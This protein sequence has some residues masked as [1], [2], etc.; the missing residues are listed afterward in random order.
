MSDDWRYFMC[1]MGENLAS[2]MV[3]VGIAEKIQAAPKDLAVLTLT[4]HRPDERGLPT[5]E[6]F[7][8]VVAVEKQL[9]NFV[10]FG[11]DAYVGRITKEGVRNFFVYTARAESRW[12][13]LVDQLIA[14]SGYRIELSIDSDPAHQTYWKYLYPTPD[15]WRVIH[16][17]SVI[18]ALEKSGDD[19]A[20]QR[21]IE[22]WSYFPDE[23]MARRFA[24]WA[25]SDRFTLDAENSGPGD[26]GK[27]CVRLFHVG[28]TVQRTVSNHTIALRRKA[29]EFGGEYDGW[30]TVVVKSEPGQS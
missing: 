10:A 24:A 23:A 16:D 20:A 27:F 21:K 9:E 22:H 18:E 12:K 11:R 30:E 15:D 29:E 7:D 17:M 25:T 6:E 14:E 8:A 2:I 1:Q 3:D 5:N 13:T 28:S 19:P 26:N 4:Y